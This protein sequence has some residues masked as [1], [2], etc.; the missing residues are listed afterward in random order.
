MNNQNQVNNYGMMPQQFGGS[1][2]AVHQQI[3]GVHGGQND[4]FNYQRFGGGGYSQQQPFHPADMQSPGVSTMGR[5][6]TGNF[7]AGAYAG[8]NGGMYQGAVHKGYANRGNDRSHRGGYFQ[9]QQQPY[10]QP[11]NQ[12]A[13]D[14]Y[15]DT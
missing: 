4:H 8:G 5:A 2:Y 7:N 15:Q 6:S 3:G 9:N 12:S 10:R 14:F 11:T 13:Q 1:S